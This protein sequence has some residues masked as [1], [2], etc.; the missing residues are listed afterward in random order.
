V[1][2]GARWLLPPPAV[3]HVAVDPQRD[4]RL[5]NA[6]PAVVDSKDTLYIETEAGMRL[7]PNATARIESH[8]LSQRDVVIR[9]NSLG[10]RGPEPGEPGRSGA[11]VLFLGDSITFGDWLPE[12]ETF[13]GRVEALSRE[14]AR[15]LE[16][17]NAG[18]GGIGLANELAILEETGLSLRPDA[19]V[20]GFYLNDTAPSRGVRRIV[21]PRWLEWSVAVRH[22][23]QRWA[24]SMPATREGAAAPKQARSQRTRVRWLQ[25]IRRDF[26][27]VGEEEGDPLESETAFNGLIHKRVSDWGSA[28]SRD[29]WVRIEALFQELQRLSVQHDFRLLVV[30]FPV[31]AQ[32]EARFVYDH[33]Q[34]WLRAIT[35]DLGVP[36]LDLLPRLRALHRE[37]GAE[38]FHDHCHHTSLGNAK[39]ADWVHEFVQENF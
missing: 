38:I 11:R 37:S 4:E 22:G 33:P 23:L 25:E 7:R 12:E 16:T 19:V 10:Y 21:P 28:W 5:A 18:I 29:A 2:L 8:A 6:S 17:I 15:P 13:V 36:L 27:A 14:G 20:V 24:V 26:P 9:T 34:Q 30:A 32:V 39:I 31:R 35:D 1:E 3:V